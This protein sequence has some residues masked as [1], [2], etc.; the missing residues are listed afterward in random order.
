MR[1]GNNSS[2]CRNC[3]D[4]NISVPRAS[5]LNHLKSPLKQFCLEICP[6][7]HVHTGEIISYIPEVNEKMEISQPERD[8][9]H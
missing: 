5:K 2:N 7:T 1:K 6:I 8:T 9:A 4:R 3:G